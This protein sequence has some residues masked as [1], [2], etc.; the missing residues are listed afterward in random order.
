MKR[1]LALL[2]VVLGLGSAALALHLVGVAT[3][4]LDLLLMGKS[5]AH[6]LLLGLASVS[7]ALGAIGYPEK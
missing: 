7:V 2:S 5:I 3:N 6:C 4:I 1:L